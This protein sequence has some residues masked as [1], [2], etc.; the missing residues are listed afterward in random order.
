VED[1][2]RRAQI[3]ELQAAGKDAP[4]VASIP[5]VIAAQ[6][7]VIPLRRKAGA[8]EVATVPGFTETARRA[9]ERLLGAPVTARP[10]D[11]GAVHV[12]LSRIYLRKD[13][14][15]FNTF[16]DEDFLEKP[17]SDALLR[18]EKEHEPVKPLLFDDPDRIHLLDMSY[19][20]VLE[21]IDRRPWS[22]PFDE[23]KAADLPMLLPGEAP[24]GDARPL[25]ARE[26]PL[27]SRVV[28][29]ARESYSNTGM[30]HRHGWRTHEVAR[31]PHMIHPSELQIVGIEPD[32]SMLF[33]VYDRI[34]RARP[35]ESP[36]Y[37]VRYCFLSFGQRLRRRLTLKVHA[38][39]HVR[40]DALR[41][42]GTALPWTSSHLTRWLGFDWKQPPPGAPSRT[43]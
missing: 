13:S 16:T 28:A 29:F 41:Y 25:L 15:N 6:F 32:G 18:E 7:G 36:V 22:I 37:E 21:P 5:R 40:R 42:A 19:R 39:H 1:L 9:L 8:L 4:L 20:S 43:P 30:E 24:D 3:E 23:E 35:G 31:L 27:P 26:E 10:F 34:R 38:I 2:E 12:F 11:E 17:E 14:L 33:Y